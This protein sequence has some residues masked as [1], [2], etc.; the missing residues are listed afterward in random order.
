MKNIALLF[1]IYL[2]IL[3][4]SCQNDNLNNSISVDCSKIHD[5]FERA[6]CLYMKNNKDNILDT[7]FLKQQVNAFRDDFF[8]LSKGELKEADSKSFKDKEKLGSPIGSDKMKILYENSYK[9]RKRFYNLDDKYNEGRRHEKDEEYE[10]ERS[11]YFSWSEVLTW[12]FDV[13]TEHKLKDSEIGMR[14]YFGAYG[15][16][17][18]NEINNS[19]GKDSID[20]TTSWRSTLFIR[21]INLKSNKIISTTNVEAEKKVNNEEEFTLTCYNLGDVCPPSCN[22]VPED[23]LTDDDLSSDN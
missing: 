4:S 9:R 12:M 23:G 22:Q 3:N 15:E 14:I 19:N 13:R 1:I 6:L 17:G 2:L 5:E 21:P 8:I 7:T 16:A 11:V 20:S 10:L 18:V